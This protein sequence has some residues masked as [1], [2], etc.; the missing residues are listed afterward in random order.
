MIVICV[1]AAF[2]VIVLGAYALAWRTMSW[3]RR[4]LLL[5]EARARAEEKGEKLQC[6]SL[7]GVR[8]ILR[9]ELELG[10]HGPHTAKSSGYP[11]EHWA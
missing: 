3:E 5:F 4:D 10:R 9:C 6:E 11:R 8:P 1:A 7:R 2:T